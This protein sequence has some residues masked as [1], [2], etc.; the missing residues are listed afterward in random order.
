MLSSHF[1]SVYIIFA[2]VLSVYY[3]HACRHYMLSSHLSSVYILSSHF[4][5]VYVILTLLLSVYYL[6]TSPQ[7]ILSSHL[8]SVYILSSHLSVVYIIFTL[9]LSIYYLHTCPRYIYYL[10]TSPQ[11]I[12]SSHFSSVCIIFTLL[13]RVCYPHTFPHCILSSPMFSMYSMF[14]SQLSRKHSIAVLN[15]CVSWSIY[16]TTYE[17]C[18]FSHKSFSPISFLCGVQPCIRYSN[19][20]QQ[21][22]SR[23]FSSPWGRFYFV[24]NSVLLGFLLLAGRHGTV[25]V[26]HKQTVGNSVER[27]KLRS[28]TLVRSAP[29]GCHHVRSA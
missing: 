29:V 24:A 2:L 17:S 26:Q 5:S 10:H 22:I 1:S 21:F 6:H 18:C 13:L 14:T 9:L 25:Y 12:L 20:Q 15:V 23:L 16:L 11:C 7:Y 8:S 3:L 19:K 28:V 4:S 27:N